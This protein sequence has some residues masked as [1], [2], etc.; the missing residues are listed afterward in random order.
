M[1]VKRKKV[2]EKKRKTNQF[3]RLRKKTSF[4][5]C[6]RMRAVACAKDLDGSHACA[7]VPVSTALVCQFKLKHGLLWEECPLYVITERLLECVQLSG[8]APSP[9]L[10]HLQVSGGINEGSALRLGYETENC[11]SRPRK[12]S[13]DDCLKTIKVWNFGEDVTKLKKRAML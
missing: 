6:E 12:Q 5:P 8:A 4:S 13:S 3:F 10:P 7:V 11:A 9:S 2:E 1:Q